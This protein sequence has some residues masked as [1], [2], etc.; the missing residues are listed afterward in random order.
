VVPF[1]SAAMGNFCSALDTFV[2]DARLI[3]SSVV[4]GAE[5]ATKTDQRG[6]FSFPLLPPGVYEL[7]VEAEGF[8]NP[9]KRIVVQ[10]GATTRVA[11]G[12]SPISIWQ[13]LL[14]AV[15]PDNRAETA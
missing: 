2:T 9:K 10:T 5:R 8:Q 3:A 14:R 7:N 1:Y 11:I 6:S 4:T 12:L 15:R 13:P